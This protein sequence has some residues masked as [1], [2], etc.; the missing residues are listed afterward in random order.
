MLT[1]KKLFDN[2]G[3]LL[4]FT[5]LNPFQFETLA[6]RLE[7]LWNKSETKRLTRD[8][9]IRSIGGGR[10]YHLSL[11]SDKLLLILVFYRT[12]IAYEFLSW[13]FNFDASNICR[14]IKRLIPLVEEAAD[15]T[16]SFAI[17]DILK[18]RKKIRTWEE[19]I[20]T[21]PD[22][23][24]LVIDSTEQKRRRPL[25]KKKQKNLYSGKKHQHALKTQVTVNGQGR[26][27]NVSHSYPARIHDKTILIK[28][29]TLD[30]LPIDLKKY[31]DKGY[32]KIQKLYPSHVVFIPVKRTRWKKELTRSE[33]IKNTKISKKRIIVEHVLSRM[34]KYA[35]LSQTYRSIDT[36]YNRHFRNIASLCNFRLLFKH[37]DTS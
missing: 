35:I 8:H 20:S 34:K 30:K 36:D 3:K 2:P 23:V 1:Y 18:K 14:L 7:P 24:E 26:I 15:P 22:L 27:I 5:G 9:R 25:N 21:Y 6:K 10:Q 4:R 11:I 16:L 17:K 32:V 37:L 33:K 28:E 13:I 31:L 19:F 29:K 12:Y